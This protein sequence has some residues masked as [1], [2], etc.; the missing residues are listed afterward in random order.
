VAGRL[1]GQLGLEPSGPTEVRLDQAI[2]GV[3]PGIIF[4]ELPSREKAK[5][6]ILK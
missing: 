5:V 4:V 1:I 6:L 2:P 3:A